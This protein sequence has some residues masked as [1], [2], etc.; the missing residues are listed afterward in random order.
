MFSLHDSL[1]RDRIVVG[2]RDNQPWKS[3]LQHS[4]EA[5]TTQLKAMGAPE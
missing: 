5:T 2:V 4:Y 1:S 3:M